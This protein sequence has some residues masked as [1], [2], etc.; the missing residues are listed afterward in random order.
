MSPTPDRVDVADAEQVGHGADVG[1]EPGG[2]GD[3]PGVA[4]GELGGPHLGAGAQVEGQ[5]RVAAGR[6]R[7]RIGLAGADVE[8]APL[9]VDGRGRPDRHAGRLGGVAGGEPEPPHLGAGGGVEGDDVAP[10]RG[11]VAGGEHLEAADPGDHEVAGHDRRAED[12]RLGV[13]ADRRLPHRRARGPVEGHDPGVE[14]ADDDAVAV[15]RRGAADV[16]VADLP[17]P[18]LLAGGGVE[19]PHVAGPVAEV[20]VAPG[21]ER[22]AGDAPQPPPVPRR[23][24]PGDGVG[25]DGGLARDRPGVGQVEADPDPLGRR[26]RLVLLGGC[27]GL[28]AGVVVAARAGGDDGQHHDRGQDRDE[29]TPTLPQL[30]HGRHRSGAAA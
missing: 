11:R 9:L 17:G 30:P 16:A 26:R 18:A 4:R 10:E 12:H 14:G 23:L 27:A 19:R 28:A 7:Q 15:E 25:A 8:D 6:R 2:V 20:D 21:H 24:Q 5:Q 3:R 22:R 13:V 29:R 1:V